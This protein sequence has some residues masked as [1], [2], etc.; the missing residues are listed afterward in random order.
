[1]NRF[2]GNWLFGRLGG[3]WPS[4]ETTTVFEESAGAALSGDRGEAEAMPS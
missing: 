1:M 3:K 4:R 2:F